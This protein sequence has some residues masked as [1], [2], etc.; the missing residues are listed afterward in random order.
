MKRA[1]VAVA[2][3]KE[4]EEEVGGR[5]VGGCMCDVKQARA[6]NDLSTRWKGREIQIIPP[7]TTTLK[8]PSFP[9]S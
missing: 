3:E 5:V 6:V 8:T 2:E 1:A 9:C 4:R 7:N